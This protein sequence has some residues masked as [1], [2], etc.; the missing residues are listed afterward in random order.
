MRKK[1]THSVLPA[2]I[3]MKEIQIEDKIIGNGHKPFI[4]AEMSG[5]HNGSKDRALELVEAAAKAGVE[6]PETS[7]LYG[8]YHDP[9]SHR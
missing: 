5:N 1:R 8:R 9:G 7:D 6:R 3:I 4:I 2:N